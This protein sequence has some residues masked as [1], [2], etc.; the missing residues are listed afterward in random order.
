MYGFEVDI[1]LRFIVFQGNDN[2]FRWMVQ[3]E[4]EFYTFLLLLFT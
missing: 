4:C 2:P 3:H 1:T